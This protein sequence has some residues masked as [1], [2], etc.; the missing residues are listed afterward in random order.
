MPPFKSVEKQVPYLQGESLDMLKLRQA[1]IGVTGEKISLNK[2][3]EVRIIYVNTDGL[4]TKGG[5]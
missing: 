5:H 2:S 3:A 4:V 1:N